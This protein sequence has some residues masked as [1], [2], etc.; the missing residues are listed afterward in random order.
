MSLKTDT[1]FRGV[2]TLCTEGYTLIGLC[3]VDM[4]MRWAVLHG[5]AD[6]DSIKHKL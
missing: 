3:K 4:L 6:L 2:Q 5:S 1:M